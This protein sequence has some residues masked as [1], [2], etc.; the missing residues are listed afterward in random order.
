MISVVI[1]VTCLIVSVNT[2]QEVTEKHHLANP[3]EIKPDIHKP[4]LPICQL[5]NQLCNKYPLPPGIIKVNK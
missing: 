1:S 4:A 2:F 3:Y 5:C